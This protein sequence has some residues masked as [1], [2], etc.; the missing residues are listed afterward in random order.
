MAKICCRNTILRAL[1]DERSSAQKNLCCIICHPPCPYP[2]LMFL[3]A[4]REARKRRPRIRP[5]SPELQSSIESRLLKERDS[6]IDSDPAL[7]MLPK[8]LI[9]PISVIKDICS[10][11]TSICSVEDIRS[12]PC[13]RTNFMFAF[14]MQLWNV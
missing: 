6:I 11:S 13:V 4:P 2:E 3:S 14:L 10:K 5:L 1:G 9:C 12:F 8:S 7:K